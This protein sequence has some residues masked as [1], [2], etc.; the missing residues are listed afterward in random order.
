MKEGQI[1]CFKNF[2]VCGGTWYFVASSLYHFDLAQTC[3]HSSNQDEG[4][5]ES[6]SICS[7]AIY[8]CALHFF[9]TILASL[10]SAS[11]LSSI[12]STSFSFDTAIRYV[13]SL[14]PNVLKNFF[15]EH[16]FYCFSMLSI[17]PSGYFFRYSFSFLE[18]SVHVPYEK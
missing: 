13:R 11:L 15:C 10:P 16:S 4:S 17:L 7:S 9:N 1:L 3:K 14:M 12:T 6:C 18:H 2:S 5:F 8:Q